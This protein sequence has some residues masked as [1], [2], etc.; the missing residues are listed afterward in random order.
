MRIDPS[1]DCTF[2]Y[3]Q[4]YQ[5]VNQAGNWNTRI[6]SFKFSSCGQALVSSA[7]TVG[8]S[9]NPSTYGQSVTFTAT[10]TPSSGTGTPT[11]SVSFK[12]GSTTLGS[13]AL[14]AS[15][16][17][18]F[19]TS[20]LA[21]GAHSITGV[22]SGDAT[23]SGSTSAAL[24]QTVNPASTTTTLT[25]SLNPSTFGTSVKFTATVSPAT[26]TG[27]VQFFDGPTSLGSASLSAGAASLSTSALAAGAHSITATYS[28]DANDSASTSSILTQTV[29]NLIATSTS[30][31]S[32]PNPSVRGQ[33]VTFTAAVV[34][35]SG[36]GTPT[37]T[38]TFLNGSAVIGSSALNASGVA[39]LVYSGLSA[40]T[41]SIT[42]KYS[43]NANYN[44]STSAVLSQV[45]RRR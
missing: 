35:S 11:G 18:T 16:V 17:A 20:S 2:W 22:Y 19:S 28:G 43:G 29:N 42:A 14:N 5:A 23:F 34:P 39:T 21:G 30:L 37:G 33:N 1:D 6:G 40:G 31:K 7:T 26:A 9:L 10:V 36:T 4:E 3:T 27:T 13:S 12:D 25:S 41:H 32:S 45:V 44:G 15:G 8:S 38:V 24:A